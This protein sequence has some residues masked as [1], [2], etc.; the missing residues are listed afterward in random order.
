MWKSLRDQTTDSVLCLLS[1]LKTDNC[2]TA[3]D[4]IATLYI[5]LEILLKRFY[6]RRVRRVTVRN[7]FRRIPYGHDTQLKVK[8]L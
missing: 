6:P 5:I 4:L 2:L 8:V 1:C 7:P 3:E